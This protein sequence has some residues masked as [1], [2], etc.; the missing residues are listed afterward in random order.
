[1]TTF[2]E[3]PLHDAVDIVPDVDAADGLRLDAAPTRVRPEGLLDLARSR[4]H[5]RTSR[6]GELSDRA[7][8]RIVH[9]LL[10]RMT[11]SRMTVTERIAGQPNETFV[12]GPSADDDASSLEHLE[13]EITV[14]D[15][16]A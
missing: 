15:A 5:H 2:S 14:T 16:R 10:A 1:M 8:R 9:E 7:A 6:L 12:Y 11:T 4:S 3:P 13:A